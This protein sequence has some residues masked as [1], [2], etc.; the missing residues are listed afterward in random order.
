MIFTSSVAKMN[1]LGRL[2]NNPALLNWTDDLRGSL[3]NNIIPHFFLVIAGVAVKL[4]FDYGKLQE[5]MAETAKEKAEA[6]PVKRC[7]NFLIYC[8]TSY[9]K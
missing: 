5:R 6:R 7:I 9:M 1:I 3:Y 2:I 4:L 8:V